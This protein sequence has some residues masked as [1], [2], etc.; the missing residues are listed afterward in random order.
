M[1][2]SLSMAALVQKIGEVSE[3]VAWQAGVGAMETAG[4][5]L[6]VLYAKPD[7]I[8]RFMAEGSGMMI[9][10]SLDV[11]NGRL[12][13]YTAN[14]SIHTPR[15]LRISDQVRQISDAALAEKGASDGQ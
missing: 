13:Y 14:G 4:Q 12:S 1:D 11:R 6:S 3:A 7:L 10:G 15:S 8:A 5:I 2:D 9:D